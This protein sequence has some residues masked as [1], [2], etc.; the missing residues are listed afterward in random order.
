MNRDKSFNLLLSLSFPVYELEG[1]LWV[2]FQSCAMAPTSFNLAFSYWTLACLCLMSICPASEGACFE[3]VGFG[4]EGDSIPYSLHTQVASQLLD[5]VFRHL[6]FI[7][8]CRLP[9]DRN[10]LCLCPTWVPGSWNPHRAKHK[11]CWSLGALR[12]VQCWVLEA[13]AGGQ[14]LLS[15]PLTFG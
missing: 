15:A 2:F 5:S 6:I 13:P 4:L 10:L 11:V 3:P 14:T 7:C 1:E 9:G 12:W 8:K